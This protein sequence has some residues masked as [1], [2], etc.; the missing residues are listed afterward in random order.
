MRCD[1][2]SDVQ[3]ACTRHLLVRFGVKYS[4]RDHFHSPANMPTYIHQHPVSCS[5][6]SY[7]Y[8]SIDTL[9]F[10]LD[11]VPVPSEQIAGV[12]GVGKRMGIS[13]PML[14]KDSVGFV[15]NHSKSHTV[16]SIRVLKTFSFPSVCMTYRRPVG[17]SI[18][19][20]L[21]ISRSHV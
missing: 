4:C 13:S 10:V 18:F 17:T 6:I 8:S 19:G 3:T 9:E 20:G 1:L 21:C 16:D 15:F 11:N 12:P 2:Y 5:L 14:M 7:R